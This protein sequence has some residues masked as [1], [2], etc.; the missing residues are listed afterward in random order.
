MIGANQDLAKDTD[1][2]TLA[3]NTAIISDK[4]TS[5]QLLAINHAILMGNTE[6]FR[7][8]GIYLS[9][10]EALTKGAKAL[11]L[12]KDALTEN[13]RQQ[14]LTNAAIEYGTRQTGLYDAAM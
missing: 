11:G 12:N 7:S 10:D 2:A 13:Q 14:I 6:A 4:N 3:K 1:L 5:E 8:V 9:V